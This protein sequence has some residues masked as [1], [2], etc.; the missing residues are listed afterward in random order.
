MKKIATLGFITIFCFKSHSQITKGN[1]MLGGNTGFSSTN[2]E[3]NVGSKST[4][5][6][7]RGSPNVGYFFSD[8]VAAGLRLDFLNNKQKA[9]STNTSS[10]YTTMGLGPFVRYYFL[11]S[12]SQTNILVEASYQ[13]GTE[14]GDSWKYK[15]NT[16]SLVAGPVI[17]LNTVVGMEFLVGYFSSKYM[18]YDGNNNSLQVGIGF[19]IHL[20]K[21]K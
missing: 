3:S 15:K 16:F 17:Y 9:T 2:Y 13:Y 8:K 20:E 18:D 6:V 14:K 4:F 11:Q 12:N 1:W 21:E 7:L 5:I 19:Q 10:K